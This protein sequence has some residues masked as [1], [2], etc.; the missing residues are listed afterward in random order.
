MATFQELR[1]ILL[2]LRA[3]E[4]TGSSP[5]PQPRLTDT[6]ALVADS[7]TGA[8]LTLDPALATAALDEPLQ[9]TVY[10]AVQQALT[11]V[12]KHASGAITTTTI[13]VTEDHLHRRVRNLAPTGHPAPALPGSGLGLVGLRERALTH[14]GTLDAGPRP[15][16]GF[17]MTL[18]LPLSP[19]HDTADRCTD[20]TPTCRPQPSGRVVRLLA[21]A[22]RALAAPFP[23]PLR[24]AE[25]TA[26]GRPSPLG[27]AHGTARPGGRLAQRL[28]RGGVPRGC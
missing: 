28:V 21:S 16:G 23:P 20:T 7:H 14:H 25:G 18:H 26:V 11:N 4:P 3:P 10:R 9:R 17:Q 24:T 2:V 8:I 15:D 1:S 27:Q 12:R 6:P 13:G 5:G 22:A 19:E